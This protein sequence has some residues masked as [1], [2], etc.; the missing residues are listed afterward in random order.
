MLQMLRAARGTDQ[1]SAPPRRSSQWSEGKQTCQNSS[2]DVA[3]MAESDPKPDIA[4]PGTSRCSKLALLS[5]SKPRSASCQI[6]R[7]DEVLRDLR[8]SSPC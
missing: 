1:R 5:Y 7:A 6:C 2:S 3:P 8:G 4:R